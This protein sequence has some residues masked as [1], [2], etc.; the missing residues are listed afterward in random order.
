MDSIMQG[1]AACQKWM[2]QVAEVFVAANQPI[3]WMTPVG[4]TIKQRYLRW[5]SKVIKTSVGDIIRQNRIRV[6]RD[7]LDRR[8]MVNGLAPNLVHSLDAAAMV[9]SVNHARD[10]G[11]KEFGAVHDSFATTAKH[12]AQLAT[13]IR[14]AYVQIFEPDFLA[15]FKRDLES[16]LPDGVELPDLPPAGNLRVTDLQNSKYFF[17]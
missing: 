8:K 1:T 15:Q 4:L 16:Q 10:N 7:D 11:V 3:R 13:S 12:S 5:N 17:N 14:S 6:D 9:A 2:S